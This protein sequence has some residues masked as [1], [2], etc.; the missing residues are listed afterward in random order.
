MSKKPTT[1]L[2]TP[3]GSKH[4]LLHSC[5]A[6]CAGPIMDDIR[7]ASIDFT[8]LFYNPNI[9]PT[10]EY[11]LRKEENIRYA[12]KLGVPFVDLD[13]DKDR[14]FERVKGLEWE[15]ER[16]ARCTAC[17]DMRFEHSALYARE[18]GFTVFTSTLG[19]SRWK[20]MVQ[21][22]ACGERAAA[23]HGDLQYW[24]YNWR[25]GGGSQRMIEI[26]KEESF[27]QQEYCGCVYSLRDS[28][29]HRTAQGRPKIVR[30]VKF[31]G[32]DETAG[33]VPP[34]A[35]TGISKR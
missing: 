31:Y 17:F 22:N 20:D 15:P 24:T 8:V 27:Y 25:K 12:E 21:I 32:R 35:A 6:P 13:Y 3:D 11:E 30:G 28:N 23:R 26:A 14:W 18:H 34:E 16:G 33:A 29:R 4:I 5:C 7:A 10:A 9:H 19:I 1:P 2:Q